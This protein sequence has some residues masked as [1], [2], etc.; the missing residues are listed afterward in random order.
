MAQL[1]LFLDS[2]A[3]MLANEAA[4]RLLARDAQGAA[5]ALAELEREDPA[6]PAAG[7]L[8]ALVQFAWEGE[9]PARR[10][11]D[12][13]RAAARLE[14]HIAPAAS[15]ALGGR[16]LAF[17]ERYYLDL[18]AVAAQLAYDQA[19][20]KAHA[21]FLLQRGG[22]FAASEQAALGIPD[23]EDIPEA[24][25]WLTAARH[26]L[27]GF[28]AARP[29]L[30]ALCWLAPRRAAGLV[31]NLGD[32]LL[33]RDWDAFSSSD[34]TATPDAEVPAWFPAWYLVQHHAAAADLE[35]A[36]SHP[37]P[38]CAAARLVAS[39]LDREREGSST[40]LVGL[41]QRLRDLNS[42]L[43]AL[44]MQRRTVFHR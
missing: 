44:Y 9:P 43:F 27:R 22:D 25:E 11:F 21:A 24:L 13:A 12:I 4:E 2:R 18:A 7:A 19:H 8:R 41:R 1:D 35:V 10:A 36:S 42:D 32:E 20:P 3:V 14:E 17:V 39:I 29:T 37:S 38:A 33:E 6:Y 28:G 34:W 31:A 26:R 5:S 16:G 40:L 15:L 30:F 23:W